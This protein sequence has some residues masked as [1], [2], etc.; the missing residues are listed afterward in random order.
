[1]RAVLDFQSFLITL[2]NLNIRIIL[3]NR[4]TLN[5]RITLI[6][7]ITLSIRNY[8]S[9]SAHHSSLIHSPSSSTFL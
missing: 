1:M 3:I 9:L 6:T 7:L 8:Q 2:I 4:S 5:I